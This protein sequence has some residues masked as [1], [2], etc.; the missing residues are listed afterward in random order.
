MARSDLHGIHPSN[1]RPFN[2]LGDRGPKI[3]MVLIQ[4]G[5]ILHPD[6]RTRKLL[7]TD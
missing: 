4:A 5:V 7:A 6:G 2:Y 1:P 3:E